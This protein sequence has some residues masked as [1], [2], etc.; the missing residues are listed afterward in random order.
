LHDLFEDFCT[1]FNQADTVIVAPVYTAGE[2]PIEGADRD[3]L[4]EGLKSHG[5]RRALALKGPEDLARLVREEAQSGDMVIC[6]GAGDI[7]QWAHALPDALKELG[8]GA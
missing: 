4:V 5:H 3:H 6:L 8:G 7:T 2:A 1:A